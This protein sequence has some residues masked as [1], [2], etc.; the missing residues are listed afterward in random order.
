MQRRG[1]GLQLLVPA[2]AC[3]TRYDP[4]PTTTTTDDPTTDDRR[5]TTTTTQVARARGVLGSEWLCDVEQAP[6]RLV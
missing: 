6:G 1:I 5:P 3:E 4:R 2:R